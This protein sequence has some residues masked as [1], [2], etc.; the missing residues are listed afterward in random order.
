MVECGGEEG[1]VKL[2][3]YKCTNMHEYIERMRFNEIRFNREPDRCT[4]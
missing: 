2:Y 4:L 1:E 3:K